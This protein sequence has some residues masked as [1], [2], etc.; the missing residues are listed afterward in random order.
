MSQSTVSRIG[1]GFAL[2][3]HLVESFKVS[4]DPQFIDKVRD[5]VGPH[6]NPPEAAVVLCV[7]AKA[8]ATPLAA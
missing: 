2:K 8:R 1:R 4:A 7:L 6:L 3:P 5:I